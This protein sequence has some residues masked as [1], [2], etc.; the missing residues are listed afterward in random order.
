[1]EKEAP[2]TSVMDPPAA[3]FSI[4]SPVKVQGS[5]T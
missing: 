3:F 1:M 2:S 4:A 5:I